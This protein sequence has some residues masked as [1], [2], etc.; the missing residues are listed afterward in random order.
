MSAHLGKVTVTVIADR[1]VGR[2]ADHLLMQ[3]ERF[4]QICVEFL[5][6]DPT[7]DPAAFIEEIR[8]IVLSPTEEGA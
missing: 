7:R 1:I 4:R 2:E 8:A 6:N 3:A 5:I